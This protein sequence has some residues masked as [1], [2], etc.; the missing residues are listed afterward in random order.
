VVT[1][2][3]DVTIAALVA[4]EMDYTTAIATSIAA[5]VGGSPL[6]VLYSM[7]EKPLIYLVSRPE[8]TT[9]SALRGG[10]IGHG[11]T[12]GAHWQATVAMV[13]YLGLDPTQ[14]VQL[15]STG[16]VE[17]GVA[18]LLS[19]AAA[20]VTLTPPYDSLA[21]KEG[22][23]R[24]VD[25]GQVLDNLP[26]T[27]LVALRAKRERDPDQIRR[28]IRAFL[29]G[30]R[31]AREHSEDVIALIQK[32]WDL[33]RESARLVAENTVPVFNSRGEVADGVIQT[34]LD[35]GRH[36]VGIGGSDLTVKDVADWTFVR[37]ARVDLS[38]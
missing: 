7:Q 23:H 3:T 24:L 10:I 17:K 34:L 14:D 8:I 4:G 35:S 25:G 2:R 36:E 15:V 33:D 9:A 29:K 11:G 27:G 26:E 16:D 6:I 13:K 30:V 28:V 19:G 37:E 5:I 21:V 18:M 32:D 1:A 12:R 20:A 38:P 31:Y 22:A